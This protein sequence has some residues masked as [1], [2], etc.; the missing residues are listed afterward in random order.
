MDCWYLKHGLH[1]D[2]TVNGYRA[3]PCCQ[4]KANENVSVP[5]PQDIHKHDILKNLKNDFDNDIKNPGCESCWTQEKLF[6][7]SKRLDAP[8]KDKWQDIQ[9]WDLRP[10]N[11][12]NLKC[13]MCMP[14]L[15]TKWYEDVDIWK[16]YND[17]NFSIDQIRTKQ[18]FDWDYVKENT[19]NKALKIYIAGG[20][21]FYMKEVINFLE[22]L[23]QF[24]FNCKNTEIMINTNGI[25]FNDKMITLLKKFQKLVLIVS[26]D[27]YGQVDELIRYPTVFSEKLKFI[28]QC[29]KFADI[30]L[31]VTVSALNL[32]DLSLLQLKFHRYNLQFYK[33]DAPD[34]LSIDSLHPKVIKKAKK[35]YST[36]HKNK[37]I[38]DM[39]S[40]YSYNKNNAEK[41]KEYLL[42][43]DRK[44]NTDSLKIIPWCFRV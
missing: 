32:L 24:K 35:I 36:K 43:L 22:Y 12:C 5:N 9:V 3:S 15:S 31:N 6:S 38:F 13:V 26:I 42:D 16:K 19:K 11:T 30:R 33:L 39:L 28:K 23:S 25:S 1:L 29:R 20:E 44:R 17:S 2:L 27:G 34:F 18:K 7:H 10:G 40:N 8:T 37:L 41:L 4:Y 14:H 21:P